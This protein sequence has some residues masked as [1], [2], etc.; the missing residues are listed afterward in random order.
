MPSALWFLAVLLLVRE[1]PLLRERV[2][3]GDR[4]QLVRS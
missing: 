3:C 2:A 4:K 1:S